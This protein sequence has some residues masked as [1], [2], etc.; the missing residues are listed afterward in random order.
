MGKF[1]C[2]LGVSCL[3]TL[4]FHG[5]TIKA[6]R[7]HNS[8]I[9][10]LTPY[11]HPINTNF[12]IEARAGIAIYTGELS[13][14]NDGDL[15]NGYKNFG[16]GL[17][18]DYRITH[19]L[20]VAAKMKRFRLASSSEPEFW[21]N[22]SFNTKNIQYSLSFEHNLFKHADHE[23]LS[24]RV[25]PYLSL[26]IGRNQ[27][28]VTVSDPPNE[29]TDEIKETA[30][31]F[32]MGGGVGYYINQTTHVALEVHYYATNSDNLDGTFLGSGDGVN[33]GYLMVELK[34]NWQIANGFVY[35]NH[36]K[37]QGM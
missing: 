30:L 33:D 5:Q 36:L 29:P 7:K 16:W 35:K 18:V 12:S 24:R 15:Q 27:Y 22:R 28:R 37:R 3:C 17:G 23:D 26:G 32:P 6:Y 13:A 20:K 4:N 14:L 2:L 1:W 21:S 19:Y 11:A 25:N 31:V 10:Y 9:N 34:Y 8:K